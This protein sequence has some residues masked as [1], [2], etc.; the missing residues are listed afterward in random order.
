MKSAASLEFRI[1]RITARTAAI[2]GLALFVSAGTLRYWQGWTYLAVQLASMTATNIYLLRHDRELARRRLAIVEVGE[3]ERV[4]KLFFALMQPMVL[5]ILVLSG[6]DRRFGWSAVSLAVVMVGWAGYAAGVLIVGLVFREN[7]HASSVIEVGEQ[8]TVVATGPYRSVRHPMYSG[9]LLGAL[10]TP[11]A[12]GSYVA[13]ALFIPLVGLFVV[14]LLAEERFLRGALR[15]Y[16][17]YMRQTRK[18]LVP[19]VW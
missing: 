14:R 9:A 17:E 12:L 13:E 15:G 8:Q 16:D 10:A 3:T 18:R 4:H 1:H 2:A 11:L 6:L 19:G 7:S 5:G